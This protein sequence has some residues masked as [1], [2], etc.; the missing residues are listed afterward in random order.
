M[1]PWAGYGHPRHLSFSV[2]NTGSG[3]VGTN[4]VQVRLST[5]RLIPSIMFTSLSIKYKRTKSDRSNSVPW[6]SVLH[7][8][9]HRVF[10]LPDALGQIRHTILD[11][12]L[13]A[14][15]HLFLFGG[16]VEKITVYR[17][18]AAAVD[19]CHLLWAEKLLLV[20]VMLL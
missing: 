2:Q 17:V 5:L 16:E 1:T 4:A 12:L 19:L 20:D 8:L 14:S 10:L 11:L 7:C 6:H 15:D 3:G 13:Y 18:G 9:F